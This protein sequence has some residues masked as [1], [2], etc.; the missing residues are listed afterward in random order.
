MAVVEVVVVVVM[1]VSVVVVVLA[2]AVTALAA[3]SVFAFRLLADGAGSLAERRCALPS[4]RGAEIRP[5]SSESVN[6]GAL[7]SVPSSILFM[8][9]WRSCPVGEL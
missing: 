1:V 4:I 3:V 6:C 8:K 9:I 5:K 7:C 2:A